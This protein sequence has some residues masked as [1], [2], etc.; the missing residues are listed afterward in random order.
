MATSVSTAQPIKWVGNANG[1]PGRFVTK[2]EGTSE[3]FA[4]GDLVVYDIS[5]NGVVGLTASNGVPD[6]VEFLGIA[7]EAAS[8]TA[9]TPI[10]IQI[11]RHDDLFTATLCSGEDTLVAPDQDNVGQLGGL[12]KMDSNNN[13]VYAVDEGTATHVK[14]EG[15]NGQDL[16]RLG[17]SPGDATTP[18]MAAGD[19]VVFRFLAAALDGDGGQA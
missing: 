19:R 2:A 6:A 10:E 4:K 14:I 15:I 7:Q 3:T 11:P 16:T 12:I 18:T 8:G 17:G 5:E 1:S 9:G 13:S